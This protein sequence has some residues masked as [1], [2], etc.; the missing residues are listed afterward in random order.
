MR[1]R[2]AVAPAKPAARG[3]LDRSWRIQS[4]RTTF[5]SEML[6]LMVSLYS[7]KPSF[8]QFGHEDIYSLERV[9]PT[10]SASTC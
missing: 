3:A 5:K 1:K 6:T 2:G 8:L 7:M 9:V 4:F 10:I